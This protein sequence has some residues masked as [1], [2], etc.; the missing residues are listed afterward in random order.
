MGKLAARSFSHI[1]QRQKEIKVM[2]KPLLSIGIIFKNE[3]R[4]LERCLKSLEPLRE[5][6]PCELVMAD[7][8]SN[9]GSRLIAEKY[10]DTLFDFE[11][12]ND[13]A[14]ARNAVM[15][16]CS[17]KWYFSIDCDE[18]VGG[19][20]QEFI[21]FIKTDHEFKY[22]GI[23]VR[24]YQNADLDKGDDYSDFYACRLILM[25]TGLRYVGAIHE[26]WPTELDGTPK[27]LVLQHVLLHHDGYMYIDEETSREKTERNMV[28]L[29]K[30]MEEDPENIVTLMQCIESSDG[31]TECIDFIRKGV[32]AVEEQ[33]QGWKIF[34][35]PILR[36][37]AIASFK[38]N[39]TD[40][41]K[42][43]DIARELFPTSIYTCI[44]VEFSDFAWSWNRKEYKKCIQSGERY[45]K[46]LADYEA[47]Q[48][49]RFDSLS[50]TL[51]FCGSQWKNQVLVFLAASYLYEKQPSKTVEILNMLS[52]G[53]MTVKHVGDTIRVYVHL[54]SHTNMDTAPLILRLW[55]QINQATPTEE[56]AEQRKIEF[57]RMSSEVFLPDYQKDER[58]H[59]DFCR[60]A[61]TLFLPLRGKCVLGDMAAIIDTGNAADIEKILSQQGKFDILPASIFLH[62]ME[63]GVRFPLKDKPMKLEEM[64]AL[65]SR[66]AQD[67]ERFMPLVLIA[68][69]NAEPENW[70]GLCWTRGLVMAAVR[71]YPWT[72]DER[73]E[74]QGMG[75]A[76]AFAKIESE[77]L[78][79]CY[80]SNILREDMLLALP[81]MHRFGW[82]CARAFEALGQGKPTEYIRLLRA[83]LDVCEG[84]KDMVEFLVDHTR[85]VQEILTPPDLRAMADQVRVMLARF[86]P[87]DPAVEALKQSD[88]Y[89]RVAYLI[90]G[91]PAPVWGRLPQ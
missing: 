17:G 71:T 59:E 19:D 4:C 34:G 73:G 2:P 68:T 76:R 24:N 52:G 82:F 80:N 23:T 13:F 67:R 78:P 56:R 79:R 48:Y 91:M 66:M 35:A 74:E 32:K 84:M 61:Y 5:A 33:W 10:A 88:A 21:D 7:T 65:V 42:Y 70:Q 50:S 40:L 64:D 39:L 25:S 58:Q 14:A 29:R 86:D 11:W 37:A 6:I 87:N 69:E 77:F 57:I 46:S 54:H 47:G 27:L 49:D 63:H 28:L 16:H 75:I 72:D 90:E 51:V 41:E 43:I 89:K 1:S 8:G 60:P 55:K 45:L 26:R 85:E 20:I 31:T 12:V 9:D 36:Y 53:L 15:D 44:D 81:P 38:G 62:A 22:G 3:I 30:H 18:W 83:G